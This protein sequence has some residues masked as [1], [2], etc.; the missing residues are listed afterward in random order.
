MLLLSQSHQ[1]VDCK[2][3]QSKFKCLTAA[4]KSYTGAVTGALSTVS[5]STE[6]DSFD[7]VE[8]VTGIQ[9]MEQLGFFPHQVHVHAQSDP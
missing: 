1:T 2:L 7:P 9:S 4:K 8:P 6:T 3:T 5:V